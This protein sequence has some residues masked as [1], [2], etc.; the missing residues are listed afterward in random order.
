MVGQHDFGLAKFTVGAD[1]LDLVF[2]RPLRHAQMRRQFG[3]QH[4]RGK[5]GVRLH[6]LFGDHHRVSV[7]HT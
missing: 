4:M 5:E 6:N 3:G 2:N 7:F 1:F